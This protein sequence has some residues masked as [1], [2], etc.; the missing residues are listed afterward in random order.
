MATSNI[1][2]G[3]VCLGGWVDTAFFL[4]GVSA[5]KML[6]RPFLVGPSF[7]RCQGFFRRVRG[8]S[9]LRFVFSSGVLL[10]CLRAVELYR[11]LSG[12]IARAG[13]GSG[14]IPQR[15]PSGPRLQP[16][17][18]YST[19]QPYF[20]EVPR[21]KTC[22]QRWLSR[23]GREGRQGLFRTALVLSFPTC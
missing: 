2:A 5:L 19:V 16:P 22:L 20:C 14:N 12:S 7:E 15:G 10:E 23:F 8:R 6:D 4:Q 1:G 3:F 13:A 18:L 9:T 21:K 17:R 11:S